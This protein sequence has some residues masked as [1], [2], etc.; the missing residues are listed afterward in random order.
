M[1]PSFY[2]MIKITIKFTVDTQD[3]IIIVYHSSTYMSEIISGCTTC[4]ERRRLE[5]FINNQSSKKPI[6][7]NKF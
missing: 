3:E 6:N 2:R 4:R 5:G 1:S 7:W